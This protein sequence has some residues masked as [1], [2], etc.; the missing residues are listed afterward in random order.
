MKDN[1]VN[2]YM[3]SGLL[4]MSIKHLKIF[5][6]LGLVFLYVW[7]L[8]CLFLVYMPCKMI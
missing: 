6:V 8:P 7:G 4:I 1:K 2:K 5:R 3:V